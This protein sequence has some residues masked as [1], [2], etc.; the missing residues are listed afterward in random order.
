MGTERCYWEKIYETREK[1]Y[2]YLPASLPY[3]RRSSVISLVAY[4]RVPHVL[5]A[6]LCTSVSLSSVRS[7]CGATDTFHTR[8]TI[9]VIIDRSYDCYNTIIPLPVVGLVLVLADLAG[10]PKHAEGN[11]SVTEKDDSVELFSP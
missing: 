2:I 4:R 5:Y 11:A 6:L 3:S 8:T 7:D 1:K 10:I 9:V